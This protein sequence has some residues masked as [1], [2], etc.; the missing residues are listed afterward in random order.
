MTSRVLVVDDDKALCD[1]LERGLKHHGFDVTVDGSAEGA[2]ERL[3]GEP[4][5]VLLTDLQLPGLD[6]IALCRRTAEVSPGVPVVMM[7]AFGDFEAAVAAMRAGAFDFLSKP[8]DVDLVALTLQRATEHARLEREVRQLRRRV[9]ETAYGFDEIAG[10]S[11]AMQR[12]FDILSRATESEATVLITGESGT[13]KELVARAL[14][15]QGRRQAGPF[16]A[17]NCAAMPEGLLES[18]LF[19]H[20]KGAFTDARQEKAGLLVQAN[21]GSLFLDEIGDM[22]LAMQVKLLRALQERTV[23]PVGGQREIGFDVRLMAA[24]NRDLE[25]EVAEGRFR[26]DLFFRINVIHIEVPPL[27]ARGTDK[28]LLAQMVLERTA[29]T[30]GKQVSGISAEAAEKMVTYDWPGNVRELQNCIER[31]VALTRFD[32]ITAEDLPEKIRNFRPS[33]LVILAEDPAEL[34]PLDEIERRYTLRVLQACGDNRTAAAK[35]LQVD[36]KTLRRK[37]AR[38][39]IAGGDTH[40]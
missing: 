3:S 4:I 11:A 9:D 35:I 21:Q 32:Q 31:A 30:V 40:L 13:G 36:R 7:T 22:P 25:H 27:R 12:V 26:Q 28:L 29:R 33:S 39:G 38:W 1:T 37:L 15:R 6:G 10:Q 20:T 24:T 34:V 5:D 23:R 17:I 16:I 14:H 19:G 2:L 8:V 18:E